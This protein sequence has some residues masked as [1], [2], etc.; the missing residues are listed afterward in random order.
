VRG[1]VDSPGPLSVSPLEVEDIMMTVT[2]SKSAAP[3]PVT[4]YAEAAEVVRK[5]IDS[6]GLGST[7]WYRS[8]PFTETA[9]G[10]AVHVNGVQVAFVSYNGRVWKGVEDF[11]T[12]HEEIAL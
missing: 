10:A 3:V 5:Y 9:K 11:T 2:V 7:A 1:W 8:L 4:S 12:G 6:R